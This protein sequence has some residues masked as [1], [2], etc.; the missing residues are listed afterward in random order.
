MSAVALPDGIYL[1]GGVTTEGRI[2]S[3]I[4]RFDPVSGAWAMM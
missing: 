2:S 4:Y 3:E 1:M